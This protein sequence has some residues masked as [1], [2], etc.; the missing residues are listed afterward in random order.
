MRNTGQTGFRLVSSGH[1]E[2][3]I[4]ENSVFSCKSEQVDLFI[5]RGRVYMQAACFE[6]HSW[7]IKN[8]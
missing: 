6:A 1:Q 2:D 8:V 5:N 3:K 4:L 7:F